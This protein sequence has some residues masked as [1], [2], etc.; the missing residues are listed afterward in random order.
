MFSWMDVM[1][2]CGCDEEN[3]GIQEKTI[4]PKNK[5]YKIM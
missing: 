1:G 5:G 3:W 4:D 2:L